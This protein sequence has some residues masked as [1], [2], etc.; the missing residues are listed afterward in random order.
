MGAVMATIVVGKILGALL[1]VVAPFD[2]VIIMTVPAGLSGAVRCGFIPDVY[3]VSIGIAQV[4]GRVRPV[5][6]DQRTGQLRRPRDAVGALR[7]G[8]QYKRQANS[9]L[10]D[11]EKNPTTS[12]A[13]GQG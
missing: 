11:D 10:Q 7:A 3:G 2:G 12:E 4:N 5:D 8:G 9:R 1:E 13:S 6:V